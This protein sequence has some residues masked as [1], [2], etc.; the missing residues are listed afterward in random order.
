MRCGSAAPTVTTNARI[1]LLL[2]VDGKLMGSVLPSGSSKEVF[3]SV[4]GESEL[5]SV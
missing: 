2:L 1:R 4:A 5:Q 3:L